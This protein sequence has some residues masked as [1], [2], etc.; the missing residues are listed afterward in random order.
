MGTL[1]DA[2][3]VSLGELIDKAIVSLNRATEDMVAWVEA[4]R[5]PEMPW[6]FRWAPESVRGANV[7]ATNYILAA[8]NR[9]GW[10]TV[11]TRIPPA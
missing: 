6:A 3:R 10:F 11:W 2:Q 4:I 9:C 1:I 5:D 7:G 8:A